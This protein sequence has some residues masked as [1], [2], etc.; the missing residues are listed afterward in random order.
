M[1]H[2]RFKAYFLSIFLIAQIVLPGCGTI[3]STGAMLKYDQD[4]PSSL[5]EKKEQ[6]DT[7][8]IYSGTHFDYKCFWHPEYRGTYSI[9]RLCLIDLPLSLAADT[10]I[11]PVTIP[12]QIF[13]KKTDPTVDLIWSICQWEK[14]KASS[15]EEIAL[16]I[17]IFD[18]DKANSPEVIK[19]CDELSSR[20]KKEFDWMDAQQKDDL[21]KYNKLTNK[22]FDF[23]ICRGEKFVK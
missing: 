17:K 3:V 4:Q 7:S 10:L 1:S 6:E 18:C 13:R 19:K 11:L 5:E 12:L 23:N 14:A 16:R 20:E 8:W 22:D 9:E 2:R 15:R 21:N